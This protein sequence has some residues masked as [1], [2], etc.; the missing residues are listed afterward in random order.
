MAGSHAALLDLQRTSTVPFGIGIGCMR[1]AT[2]Y[3]VVLAD[4]E[5]RRAT[6]LLGAREHSMGVL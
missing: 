3:L 5:G 6:A 2:E 4:R 1:E